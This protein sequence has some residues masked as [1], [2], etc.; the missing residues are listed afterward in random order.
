MGSKEK[1]RW[2]GTQQAVVDDLASPDHT[3]TDTKPERRRFEGRFRCLHQSP[4]GMFFPVPLH[5]I[6]DKSLKTLKVGDSCRFMPTSPCAGNFQFSGLGLD[7]S[8]TITV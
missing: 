3:K 6:L 8:A 1:I 7:I 4:L 5:A 2:S